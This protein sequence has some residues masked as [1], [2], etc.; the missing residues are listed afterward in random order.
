M[1][2]EYI[3]IIVRKELGYKKKLIIPNKV[4]NSEEEKNEFIKK[5]KL[6]INN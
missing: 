2:E 5:V 3:L 6:S 1:F 4:F